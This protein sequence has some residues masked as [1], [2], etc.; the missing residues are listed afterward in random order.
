MIDT[1]TNNRLRL[2]KTYLDVLL[3]ILKVFKE[4]VVAPG[5]ARLFVGSTVRVTVGLS[6]LATEKS[7]KVGS[8]LV[9]RSVFNVVALAA[10]S[11]EGLGALLFARFLGHGEV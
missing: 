2:R 7:V 4:S 11:L 1:G 9:T 10:F 8:L 3:G 6:R 5:D